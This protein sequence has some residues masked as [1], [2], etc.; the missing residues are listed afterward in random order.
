[1]DLL[2]ADRYLGLLS[3]L[4]ETLTSDGFIER[5]RRKATDFTR[6]RCLTF[7]VVVLFLLNLVKRA[8][9]DEL[10]EY[11]RLLR[12]DELA[13][14]AVTKSAF[15][16]A[17][18]KL[19][20]TAFIEL[21]QAQVRYFW[22]HF[23]PET[24]QGFRLVAVDGS[25]GDLP[26]TQAVCEHFGVWHPA[27]GGVCPKAR[28]SQMFDVL[29]RITIDALIAP[30]SQ[31]E[32]VLAA[33]HFQQLTSQALVLLDRGYPAFW[34]FAAIRARD[35]HFCARMSLSKWK[36][37]AKFVASGQ[38]EQVIL[39]KAD[40]QA[41]KA[42]QEHGLS[43]EPMRL[44]LLRLELDNGQVCVLATSLVDTKLWDVSLFEEL[45]A[46][47][48]PVETDYE[49][50]KSRLEVEN[51][52]GTSVQAIYQDFH[53]KVFTKNLAAILAAPTSEPIALKTQHRKHR[54]QVNMANLLSKMKDT[55]ILLLVRD[56]P[57]SLLTRLWHLMMQTIEP[58]RPGRSN[59]RTKRVKRSRFPTCYKPL[60]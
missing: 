19:K 41:R 24:W 58:V 32:R 55:V 30:K 48:W 56:N 23:E 28:L 45:Y 6:R 60:R 9:Q 2:T 27:A 13:V 44:R 36:V 12:G 59:P 10:D 38:K 47:R 31:G 16:Q 15:S 1:M 57:L 42:C 4:R 26:H 39:L 18:Q 51:W 11:F 50:M 25:M 49:Q 7:V 29:N 20:Y 53:A 14:R 21:N 35:A 46:L 43:P 22:E 40:Y 3:H 34:L 17:R 54:Y 5:H 33:Q 52:T 37:V 8:L